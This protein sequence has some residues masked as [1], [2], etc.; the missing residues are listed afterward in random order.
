[1]ILVHFLQTSNTLYSSLQIIAISGIAFFRRTPTNLM[2]QGGDVT[3]DV[4]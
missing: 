3:G 4:L 1:M 2:E